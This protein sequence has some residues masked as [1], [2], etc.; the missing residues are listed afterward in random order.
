MSLQLVMKTIRRHESARVGLLLVA[1]ALVI[2]LVFQ[3]LP[4]FY[5]LRLSMAEGLDSRRPAS[6]VSKTITVSLQIS[7]F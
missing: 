1:P 7:N 3:V 4:V 5:T 6:L 2:L